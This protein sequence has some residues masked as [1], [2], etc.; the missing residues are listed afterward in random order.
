[1]MKVLTTRKAETTLIITWKISSGTLQLQLLVQLIYAAL[2]V[3][4]V[5]Q[6]PYGRPAMLA[7]VLL[8]ILM[9]CFKTLE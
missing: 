4:V 1:M 3:V 5:F 7:Q 8:I 6:I 2:I 9:Q